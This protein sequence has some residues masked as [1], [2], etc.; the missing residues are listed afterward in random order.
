M[1]KQT[2]EF[3]TVVKNGVVQKVGKSS[4]LQPKPNFK[5]G[6]INWYQD[7]ARHKS[8]HLHLAKI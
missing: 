1:Q 8:N 7:Q 6:S 4:I 5:G 3:A 2:V